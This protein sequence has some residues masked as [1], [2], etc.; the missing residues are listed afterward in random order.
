M[1]KVIQRPADV[2]KK[3]DFMGRKDEDPKG[4]H[5]KAVIIQSVFKEVRESFLKYL[6]D[7]NTIPRKKLDFSRILVCRILIKYKVCYF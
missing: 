4:K 2:K 1:L 3:K 5:T 7:L 6:E